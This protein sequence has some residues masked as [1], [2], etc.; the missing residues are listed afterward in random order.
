MAALADTTVLS[1]FAQIRRPDLLRRTYPDLVVPPVVRAELTAGERWGLVPVCD[2]SWLE[3]APLLESEVE[4]AKTFGPKIGPGEAACLS[5][6]K[7]RGLF[8]LTDDRDARTLAVALGLEISGTLGVL[9]KL[10]HSQALNLDHADE[11]LTEMRRRGY[12][13]PVRS[14]QE[15][16]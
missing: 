16:L 9:A 12:R 7:S 4:A 1:N 13:S 11:L 14:I 8:L 10:V 15:V 6:A 5:L 3:I 2:W